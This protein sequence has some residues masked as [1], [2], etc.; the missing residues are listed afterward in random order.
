MVFDQSSRLLV[1]RA[2]QAQFIVDGMDQLQALQRELVGDLPKQRIWKSLA[3]NSR[4]RH[5]LF[6]MGW[7]R[8]Y[9]QVGGLSYP[10]NPLPKLAP[11]SHLAPAAQAASGPL[12]LLHRQQACLLN[13]VG[14]L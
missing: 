4:G 12:R 1:V 9:T 6:L 5:V 7:H 13:H 8:Q 14:G 11:G 10:P 3:D 2:H